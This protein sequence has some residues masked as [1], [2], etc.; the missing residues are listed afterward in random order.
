MLIPLIN[1]VFWQLAGLLFLGYELAYLLLVFCETANLGPEMNAL[2]DTL[3]L[4]VMHQS[5]IWIKSRC[6]LKCF[7]ILDIFSHIYKGLLHR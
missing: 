6:I 3:T 2:K 1:R 4:S 5:H 7:I